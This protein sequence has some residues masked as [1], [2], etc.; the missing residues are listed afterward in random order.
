VVT[1][2][3]TTLTPLARVVFERYL[4]ADAEYE[5][6]RSFLAQKDINRGE[7]RRALLGIMAALDVVIDEYRAEAPFTVAELGQINDLSDSEAGQF[8][9]LVRMANALDK[10]TH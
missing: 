1:P 10:L 5:A 9:T 4:M 7:A 6:A 2:D 3:A 8:R